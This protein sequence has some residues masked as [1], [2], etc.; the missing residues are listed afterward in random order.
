ME[1]I[2]NKPRRFKAK[3]IDPCYKEEICGWY[4][5]ING[6]PAIIEDPGL[7]HRYV[8]LDGIFEWIDPETLE[9]LTD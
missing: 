9:P 3:A 7:E 1:S 8:E 4:V 5:L 6:K 2:S